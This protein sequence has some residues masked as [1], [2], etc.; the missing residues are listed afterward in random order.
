M[1]AGC[2]VATKSASQALNEATQA[3]ATSPEAIGAS[4]I[5]ARNATEARNPGKCIA[6]YTA[7]LHAFPDLATAYAG[8]ARCYQSGGQNFAASV[9]DYTRALQLDPDNPLYLLG[10][11]AGELGIGDVAAAV[12][13]YKKAVS[14]PA[15]TPADALA[16][17]DEMLATETTVAVGPTLALAMSRHPADP[18]VWVA[19]ADV[20]IADDSA[21]GAEDDL[22][23]AVSL[24]SSLADPTKLMAALS[25][26]CGLEVSFHEYNQALST[27]GQAASLAAG[28]SG[29]FDNLG[30]ADA[31]LGHLDSAISD[32]SAAIGAF[33]DDVSPNAQPAGIDGFGLSFL[34]EAQG[35]LYLEDHQ[36]RAAVADYARSLAAL[37]PG[38][39]DFAARLHEDIKAARQPWAFG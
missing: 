6:D 37:P 3:G 12:G 25:R 35:R 34:L 23:R 29:A 27:C 15:S 17:I 30:A 31:A 24:A 9:H 14:S 39:P 18:L 26:I 10:R 11:A 19:A 7:G 5:D 4:L 36:P 28:N 32:L 8:R 13:D 22:A 16:A 21:A 2:S 33:D 1:V 20:A 38:N